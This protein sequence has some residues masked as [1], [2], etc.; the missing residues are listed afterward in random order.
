MN[1]NC[2]KYVKFTFVLV[3]VMAA[4]PSHATTCVAGKKF[5]VR[6]VC[7]T[8]TDEDG[9]VIA[10]TKI[11]ITPSGHPEQVKNAISGQD[12]T[13]AVSNLP[14]GEYEIR[15]K[16]SGFWDAWQ[17][18]AISGSGVKGKCTKPIHVVMVPAGGCSYVENAWKKSH[19]E[20]MNWQLATDH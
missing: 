8:V 17:L 9:A 16:Y 15:A 20:E 6:Q 18:F 4:L 10:D 12:G 11:E 2:M 7:G 1:E 14:D 5:K 3:A 19:P 13:F